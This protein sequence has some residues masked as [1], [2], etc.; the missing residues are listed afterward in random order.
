MVQRF[1]DHLYSNQIGLQQRESKFFF[2]AASLD[3]SKQYLNTSSLQSL[4]LSPF[5]LRQF[6]DWFPFYIV[7][8]ALETQQKAGTG[9]RTWPI[10]LQWLLPFL[11][12]RVGPEVGSQEFQVS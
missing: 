5:G 9:T 8:R 2:S 6:L 7:S 1:G 4:E 3:A 10:V 12:L 11:V